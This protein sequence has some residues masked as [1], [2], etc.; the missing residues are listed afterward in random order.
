MTQ[1]SRNQFLILFIGSAL[2][3][4]L[5]AQERA[6]ELKLPAPKLRIGVVTPVAQMGPNPTGVNVGL[7]LRTALVQYLSGPG[8]E[9]V[10]ID[11][12]IPM[13]IEA[14]A[15]QKN[16]TYVLYSAVTQKKPAGGFGLL[17]SVSTVANILPMTAVASR[18]A[19]MIAATAAT[20]VVNGMSQSTSL[21]KAKNEVS[22]DYKVVRTKDGGDLVNSSVKK[23][24]GQDGEDVLTPLLVDGA[25]QVLTAITDDAHGTVRAQ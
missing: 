8:L 2:V 19:A 18:V 9:V 15:V 25:T 20:T 24:A 6:P 4:T 17:R 23:K 10:P 16:C 7:P 5:A 1:I 3:G 12:V 13:Q 14:E 22:L 11:A 21:V